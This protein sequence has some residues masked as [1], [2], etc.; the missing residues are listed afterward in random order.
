[1]S[2]FCD[3][4]EAIAQ[5]ELCDKNKCPGCRKCIWI[6]ESGWAKTE[7]AKPIIS[8][9][10]TVDNSKPIEDIGS[11]VGISSITDKEYNEYQKKRSIKNFN[12]FEE[13]LDYIVKKFGGKKIE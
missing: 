4:P 11:T 13:K 12:S 8:E 10:K 2:W 7:Y 3:T 9:P 6:S 5:M 1:M